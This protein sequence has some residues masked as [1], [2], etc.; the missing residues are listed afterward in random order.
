MNTPD[1]RLVATL[2]NAADKWG[3]AGVLKVAI[4][5]WPEAHNLLEKASEGARRTPTE[6]PAVGEE[7]SDE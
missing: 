6:S 5:L 2:R 7:A 1:L 4:D 3:A